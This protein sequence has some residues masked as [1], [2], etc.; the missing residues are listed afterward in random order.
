MA[1]ARFGLPSEIAS[2][3]SDHLPGAFIIYK[4]DSSYLS[5]LDHGRI[6]ESLQ[7]GK[8]FYVLFMGWNDMNVHY[9]D[10]FSGYEAKL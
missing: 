2:A 9:S 1:L 4:A 3:I 8:V 6:V 10:K 7:Y 5:V